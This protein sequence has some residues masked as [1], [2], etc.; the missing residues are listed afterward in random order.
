MENSKRQAIATQLNRVWRKI[1]LRRRSADPIDRQRRDRQKLLDRPTDLGNSSAE[2][3]YHSEANN[4]QNPRVSALSRIADSSIFSDVLAPVSN[5]N[6]PTVNV[7]PWSAFWA[8]LATMVGGTGITSY[9]LLIAVPPTPS[10][11]GIIPISTDA[12]RLYCAQVGAE[13][14]ELPKLRSAVNLVQGWTDH[15]PLYRESQRLLK[16]WSEDLLRI[17][18]KQVN[19]GN[20][21]QAIAT[22]KIIPATSPI[23]DRAQESI[24]K[25]SSQSQDSSKIDSRFEQAMKS[26]DWND[27]FVILQSVQRMRGTYWNSYKYDKMASKLAQE[28]DGWDRLH[29]AKD[30]LLDKDS[31]D[32]N[33]RAKRLELAVKA[34]ANHQGKDKSKVKVEEAPLPTTPDPIVKA[35]KLANQINPTTYVYHEGQTLRS[36]WSKHLVQLSIGLYKAQNFNGAIEIVQKVPQDVSVYPEA[37]DWIKL[38]QAHVWAGKRHLLALMDAI[39]QVKKIP[40]T[41]SIY[42][43]AHTKQSNWQG[44]LKQQ[45]QFQW[46][47]TIASVQQPATLSL[48]IQTAKQIPAQSEVGQTIH[49]EVDTWSRQI[50]TIDNRVILAK[51]R[52]IVS[53]GE[54]L[55]N[56]KAAVHLTGKIGKDRPMGE[57]ITV[58]VA[59]WNEKIQTIEDRPILANA[60]ALATQGELSKAITVAKRITPGRALYQNAQAEIRYWDLELQEIADRQ[61]LENAIAVYRQGKISTA[62]NMAATIRRRSPIYSDARSYVTDWRLLLAPRSSRN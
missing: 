9:L 46:A 45:T 2:N 53:Q 33:T 13:K 26:G 22:A 18:R 40:K 24:A 1:Q 19:E 7:D 34:A 36:K 25:W 55:A 57:E 32:Y 29:E 6:L 44:M 47:K 3:S 12:E 30:A 11:Q 37:Q 50:E 42:T 14:K 54:S 60:V 27:A 39:S 23:Y 41:S 51:A 8:V 10:C 4:T 15:H 48:A 16:S 49:S 28:R 59:E 58:F 62:I 43:L 35:M 5:L 31:D 38:N 61:T 21:E 17:G 20:I 56:L 52:Q